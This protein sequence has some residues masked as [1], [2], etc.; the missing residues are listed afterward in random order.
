MEDADFDQDTVRLWLGIIYI[1]IYVTY[2][3]IILALRNRKFMPAYTHE[4]T[5]IRICNVISY[6]FLK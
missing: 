2:N 1:L 6:Q 3:M 4:L 5:P